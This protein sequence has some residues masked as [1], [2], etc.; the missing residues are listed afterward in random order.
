LA[1]SPPD[2]E[3]TAG[4]PLWVK[5]FGIIAVFVVLLVVVLLV[6]GGGEHGPSRHSRVSATTD[7]TA[8]HTGPTYGITHGY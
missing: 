7:T 5:V 8:S 4:T 6:F 1:E 3:P 2:R